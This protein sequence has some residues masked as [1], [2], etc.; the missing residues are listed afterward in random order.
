MSTTYADHLIWQRMQAFLPA[1]FRM[2]SELFLKRLRKVPVETVMLARAGHY[3]PEQP[4]LPRM[5]EAID[6]FYRKTH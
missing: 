4:G 1:E 5:V 3:P 6:S 2:A